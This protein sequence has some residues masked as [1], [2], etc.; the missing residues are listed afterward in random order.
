MHHYLSLFVQFNTLVV[1]V[2]SAGRLNEIFKRLIAPA[3]V[4]GA[5]FRRGAA[6]QGREEVIRIPSCHRSSP[7]SRS[8]ARPLSPALDTRPTRR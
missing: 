1:V 6:E 4:V 8:G 2:G 7:S 3:R 5:V